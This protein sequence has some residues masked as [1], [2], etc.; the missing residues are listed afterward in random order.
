MGFKS[1][2]SYLAVNAN[3]INGGEWAVRDGWGKTYHGAS[4]KESEVSCSYADS[5][6]KPEFMDHEPVRTRLDYAPTIT[7]VFQKWP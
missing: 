4:Y 7:V 6:S 2:E 5:W 3:E 1:V